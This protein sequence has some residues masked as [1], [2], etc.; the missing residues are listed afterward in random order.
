M[1]NIINGLGQIKVGVKPTPPSPLL[2]GLYGA[3]NADG[4][5]NDSFGTNN[6]TANGGLT[7]T[8]GKVNQAFN[9]NGT[10]SYINFTNKQALKING[11]FTISVWLKPSNL[12][13]S[14][15][16]V[17]QYLFE[18]G[19]GPRGFNF[20]VDNGTPGIFYV[21]NTGAANGENHYLGMGSTIPLNVW[22]HIVVI[23]N[24]GVSFRYYLNGGLIRENYQ[25]SGNV[26]YPYDTN[27]SDAYIGGSS[28]TGLLDGV[29]IWN[30]ALTQSE[31][32]E[33]YNGGNGKQYPF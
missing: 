29:T 22:S 13:N 4:N 19:G 14:F 17:S 12:S 30:R 27:Y 8:A 5:T 21:R 15:G 18:P 2:T 6:G 20:Y 1:P 9:Y 28:Y 24:P 7:Y 31:V 16:V 32:T 11:A 26:Q 3:W 23:F 10:N 33:L 25:Y